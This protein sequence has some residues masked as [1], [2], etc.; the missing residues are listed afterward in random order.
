MSEV[1]FPT[2]KFD[3]SQTPVTAAPG[4]SISHSELCGHQYLQAHIPTV[5]HNIHTI[6][7]NKIDL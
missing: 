4:D 6:K 7:V 3:G 1:Q 2:P 5:I